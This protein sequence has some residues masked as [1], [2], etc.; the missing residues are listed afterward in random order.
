MAAGGVLEA[1][2]AE[3]SARAFL[4]SATSSAP[5]VTP[6]VGELSRARFA[7]HRH[8]DRPGSAAVA[9]FVMVAT[10]ELESTITRRM[11]SAESSLLSSGVN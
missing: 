1:N 3:K 8:S 7:A 10:S 4:I 11:S 6:G 2:S 5:L 9:M